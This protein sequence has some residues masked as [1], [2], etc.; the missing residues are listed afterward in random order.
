M[1]FVRHGTLTASTVTTVTLPSR[2]APTAAGAIGHA[3]ITNVDGADKIYF[4]VLSNANSS[5]VPTVAGN[6]CEV[7]PAVPGSM[8][9]PLPTEGG[10][11]VLVKMISSGTPVYSVRAE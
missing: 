1:A 2:L 8:T 11:P 4:Q 3:E 5:T 9:V 7:L 10:D 6:D